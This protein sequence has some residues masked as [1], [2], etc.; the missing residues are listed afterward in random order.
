MAATATYD[1]VNMNDSRNSASGEPWTG[2]KP[3]VEGVLTPSDAGFSR[4]LR[5]LSEDGLSVHPG[6][7]IDNVVLVEQIGAGGMGEVWLGNDRELGTQIAVKLMPARFMNDRVQGLRFLREAHAA[8][9]LDHPNIVRIFRHGVEGGRRFIMME[10]VDGM[11]LSQ[12][13]RRKGL[14]TPTQALRLAR[15]GAAALDHA[16]SRGVAHRDIKPSNLILT[17]IGQVKV[18]DFGLATLSLR[19]PK[20]PQA[21]YETLTHAQAFV[22]TPRYAAPEQVIGDAADVR[23]DIYSLGVTMLELLCGREVFSPKTES[24]F[25]QVADFHPRFDTPEFLALEA[26]LQRLIM[27]SCSPEP[28]ARPWPMALIEAVDDLLIGGSGVRAM[29]SWSQVPTSG[30]G[31]GEKED[32]IGRE[33]DLLGLSG[34]F[35]SSRVVTLCGPA[36]VGKTSLARS[37]AHQAAAK[38]ANGAWFCDLREAKTAE[39]VAK[40]I[41]TG[42]DIRNHGEDVL[43]MILATLANRRECLV[44]IDN[45]EHVLP[46][47]ASITSKLIQG[48]N[49][50]RFLL[51]SRE[52]VRVSGESVYPVKPLPVPTAH[53]IPENY[54]DSGVP[55][56]ISESPAVQ[57]LVNLAARARPGFTLNSQN[58]HAIAAL[59]AKLDGLPLAITLAAARIRATNI[60]SILKRLERRFDLLSDES[61]SSKDSR[62]TSLRAALEWSWTLLRPWEQTA[63]SQLSV[64]VGGFT[65]EAAEEIVDT[66]PWP[67]APWVMD[68]V[69]A[70]ADKHLLTVTPH[71]H[72][73][74]R[75]GMLESVREFAAAK[76]ASVDSGQTDK[77]STERRHWLHFAQDGDPM[78][79]LAM[80]SGSVREIKGSD[81]GNYLAAFRRAEAAG[82]MVSAS[83]TGCMSVFLTTRFARHPQAANLLT[84]LERL[85]FEGPESECVRQVLNARVACR[86]VPNDVA[87]EIAY[88]ALE[89][90]KI[91]SNELYQIPALIALAE[92]GTTGL[93]S[94]EFDASKQAYEIAIRYPGTEELQVGMLRKMATTAAGTGKPEEA[95]QYLELAEKTYRPGMWPLHRVLIDESRMFLRMFAGRLREALALSREVDRRLVLLT[96]TEAPA[97]IMTCIL[98]LF[99]GELELC[100]KLLDA[101]ESVTRFHGNLSNDLMIQC[102]RYHLHFQQHGI[103]VHAEDYLIE[104]ASQ[105]SDA[106]SYFSNGN[107]LLGLASWSA[108]MRGD[109]PRATEI[110]QRAVSVVKDETRAG[111]WPR[112]GLSSALALQGGFDR[113]IP[114]AESALTSA[115][116]D[117]HERTVAQV[118]LHWVKLQ[119]LPH[120][121]EAEAANFLAEADHF[122]DERSQWLEREQVGPGSMMRIMFDC[123]LR[124]R[125][126][127]K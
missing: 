47:V 84:E 52:P 11:D 96:S 121:T 117:W 19:E 8:A 33:Q 112:I 70:L 29:A 44:V 78:K 53:S 64:C 99:L 20:D 77:P 69:Q 76:L 92:I 2:L 14:L 74:V 30:F 54:A 3:G 55:P 45:C 97:S 83:R 22:G 116:Q 98:C 79:P 118:N 7:E 5:G 72:Q 109:I 6:A 38:L 111:P 113:A 125:A 21:I 63:L 124:L 10:Y 106:M 41:A 88:K 35:E 32:L 34:S 15:Q 81:L 26:P 56:E 13:V 89:A 39:D 103:S 71:E 1:G 67:D 46:H 60:E 90:A 17:S 9:R 24:I 51:T 73:H 127:I 58:A 49:K 94:A 25:G 42:L 110:G 104:S 100:S 48:T 50:V 18:A 61:A 65:L 107:S 120:L 37:Y 28:N 57:L 12:Y 66:S 126:S 40:A 102:Y 31:L 23:A 75:F 43:G 82:D 68:I 4:V 105:V 59:V 95:E 93:W 87:F 80:A 115:G 16:A 108:A 119:Q 85:P 101:R 91:L 27:A 62:H 122:I 123:L 36:G 114:M 86:R